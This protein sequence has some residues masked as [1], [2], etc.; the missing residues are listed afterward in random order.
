VISHAHNPEGNVDL[1]ALLLLRQKLESESARIQAELARIDEKLTEN[2]RQ[3]GA[4]LFDA[5]FGDD[6]TR[7]SRH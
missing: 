3:E 2:K 1:A 6:P 4:S 7:K 5:A